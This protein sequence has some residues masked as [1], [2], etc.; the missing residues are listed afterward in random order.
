MSI[1]VNINWTVDGRK[2]EKLGKKSIFVN[3][4]GWAGAEEGR[5]GE[6]CG[7]ELAVIIIVQVNNF[8]P[9]SS[10][11]TRTRIHPYCHIYRD[12]VWPE[13]DVMMITMMILSIHT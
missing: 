11:F 9:S 1:I 4:D 13:D 3:D 7:D 12:V 5:M 8:F 2:H 10:P 6:G